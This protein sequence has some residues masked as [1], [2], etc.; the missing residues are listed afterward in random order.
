MAVRL[1]LGDPRGAERAAGAAL[2]SITTGTCQASL[3]FWPMARARI[4]FEPPA[5]NGTMNMMRLVGYC[6]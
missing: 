3:S 4:S 6:A 2:V 5:A 1:G